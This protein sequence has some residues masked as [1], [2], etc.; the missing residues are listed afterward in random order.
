MSVPKK[1]SFTKTGLALYTML[2]IIGAFILQA[3]IYAVNTGPIQ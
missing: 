1:I 2:T 3:I